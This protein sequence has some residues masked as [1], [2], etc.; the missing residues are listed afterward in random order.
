MLP[1]VWKVHIAQNNI[2]GNKIN[3][4]YRMKL[5]S[6]NKLLPV[7]VK[8]HLPQNCRKRF[9]YTINKNI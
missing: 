2:D 1:T 8:L 3:F 6:Q 9:D 4:K 7:H 5:L